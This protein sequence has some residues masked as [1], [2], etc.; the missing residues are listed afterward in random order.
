[1]DIL[2][3][4]RERRSCRAFKPDPV[5]GAILKKIMEQALKAPSWANTQPWEFAVVTGKPL[6]EIQD[7]FMARGVKNP[8][9][10]IHR[11]YEFPEPH[12]GRIRALAPKGRAEMTQEEQEQR[13]LANFEHYGAPAV[14]YILV[15]RNFFYQSQGINVWSIYDC[16]LACENLMLAAVNEGLATVVQ[17]QAVTHPDII[18]K[19]TGIPDSKLIAMGIAI[20]YPDWNAPRN[21]RRSTRESFDNVVTWYGSH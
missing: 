16:G 3:A 4:I 20:G 2:D 17:A 11:P 8:T 9:P 19:V 5:P 21:E 18:R 1:M 13:V 12:M 7:G 15:G 14:I 6:K 10:D